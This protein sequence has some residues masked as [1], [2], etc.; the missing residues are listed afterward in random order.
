MIDGVIWCKDGNQLKEKENLDLHK[1][2]TSISD[3]VEVQWKRCGKDCGYTLATET[4]V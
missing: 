4:T 1:K 3:K 2:R